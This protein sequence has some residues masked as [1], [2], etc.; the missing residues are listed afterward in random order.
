MAKTVPPGPDAREREYEAIAEERIRRAL[1]SEEARRRAARVDL[2]VAQFVREARELGVALS[3]DFIGLLLLAPEAATRP[4]ETREQREVLFHRRCL[5]L[6]RLGR[7]PKEAEAEARQL[8]RKDRG[9]VESDD[10]S[11]RAV[12]VVASFFP[13]EALRRAPIRDLV[14]RITRD[15]IGPIARRRDQNGAAYVKATIDDLGP[16]RMDHLLEEFLLRASPGPSLTAA[17]PWGR[18]ETS[19]T[20]GRAEAE[21]A[22]A[23][24]GWREHYA[25]LKK[26]R[27]TFE[28]EEGET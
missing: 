19:D 26:R 28:E 17:T 4:L 11:K 15:A 16:G 27:Q 25:D 1:C 6:L 10:R 14:Y 18:A 7:R 8:E 12:R 24:A 2:L 5:A 3:P 13:R 9:G 20:W 23:I 21:L 22:L